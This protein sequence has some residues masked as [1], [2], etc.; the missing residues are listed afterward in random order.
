MITITCS[1]ETV[2]NP[3]SSPLATDPRR[4]LVPLEP[5]LWS[6]IGGGAPKGGW[7]AAE[8]GWVADAVKT[9]AP[10]GGW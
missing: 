2:R 4:T 9:Q 3:L 10:K 1:A 7:A 6:H 5:A 8:S